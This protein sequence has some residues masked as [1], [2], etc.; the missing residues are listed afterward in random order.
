MISDCAIFISAYK[1]SDFLKVERIE[2]GWGDPLIVARAN[3]I[4]LRI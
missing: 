3:K 1:V 2:D 4:F